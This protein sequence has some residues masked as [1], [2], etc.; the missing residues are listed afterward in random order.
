MKLVSV[1]KFSFVEKVSTP[2]LIYSSGILLHYRANISH[3]NSQSK[4][5]SQWCESSALKIRSIKRH[6]GREKSSSVYRD[7]NQ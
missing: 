6:V 2:V 5:P 3:H 1:M 7:L 4:I